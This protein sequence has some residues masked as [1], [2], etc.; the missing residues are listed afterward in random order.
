MLDAISGSTNGKHITLVYR[1][2][3]SLD[4]SLFFARSSQLPWC[5][6]SV[7]FLRHGE[8]SLAT[9]AEDLFLTDIVDEQGGSKLPLAVGFR[10]ALGREEVGY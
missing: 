7:F 9:Q 2:F 4:L 5:S 1:G 3:V 8:R 6:S 10:F